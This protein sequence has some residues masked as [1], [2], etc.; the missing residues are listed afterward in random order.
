MFPRNGRTSA[1]TASMRRA[2]L[3]LTAAVAMLLAFAGAVLAQD[4]STASP[5]SAEGDVIQDRYIVV[6]KDGVSQ[7]PE[8]VAEDQARRLG[9]EISQTYRHALKGYAA[10]I[11]AERLDDV[12]ADPS[13]AYVEPD[14]L[15][16]TAEQTLP[17]GIDL[18]DADVSST[19][20][21]NHEGEVS[22]VNAYIIDTGIDRNHSDLNVVNHV[23]FAGGKNRDCNGH[24]THVAG[25][26]AARDND[27]DVVGVAPGAPLTGVKVLGCNGS[28]SMSNVIKGVDWVTE[29]ADVDG[30]DDTLGNSDDN[31]AIANMSLGGGTSKAL[32]KAVKR[33]AASGVFYSVAAGNKGKSACKQSPAR[34]GAGTN[35]GIMTTAA[36]DQS[37]REASFSNYGSCVDVWAPGVS[38]LSTRLGGGTVTLSG[39]SMASPHVGGTGALYLSAHKGVTAAAVEEQ[40]KADSVAPG[41]KSKNGDQIERVYAGKY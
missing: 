23:N 9:L 1:A 27:A 38:V 11:P 6:L 24:G 8:R 5:D 16:K 17:Y 30:P 15:V 32:D 29:N 20:A 21:G 26:V 10:R 37:D 36:T 4:P 31:P 34:A 33:S 19:A 12:R 2:M 14:K 13:V 25:T 7:A 40:L 3:V 18:I 39:T 35:N 22:G 28:G 41:T